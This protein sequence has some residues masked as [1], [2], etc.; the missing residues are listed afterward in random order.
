MP[1]G[2]SRSLEAQEDLDGKVFVLPG[3]SSE[4][5]NWLLR[6]ASLV[7]YPTSAEGFGLVPYEA[8]RFGTP[9]VYVGF[10]PLAELGGGQPGVAYSWEPEALADGAEALL[11][12]PALARQQVLASISGG[13]PYTWGRAAE[14]L[15]EMYRR[16]L[17]RAAL[18]LE[19]AD[20]LPSLVG[21]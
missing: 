15:A 11:T 16:L 19:G 9:T 13:A 12:D 1:W 2:S 20:C 8:A 4:E 3:V 10:G 21:G 7:L 18:R 14:S 6:H 5:R 17:A